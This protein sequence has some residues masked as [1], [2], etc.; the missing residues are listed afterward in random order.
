[1]CSPTKMPGTAVAMGLNSP[2]ISAGASGLGSQVSM[3]LTPPQQYST[4]HG[5]ARSRHVATRPRALAAVSPSARAEDLALVQPDRLEQALLGD[6]RL[7]PLEPAQPSAGH[8]GGDPV[9]AADSVGSGSRHPA[10][11][12][13]DC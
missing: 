1:M 6:A 9:P 10:R 2:R 5:F 11:L 4:M 3:W 7:Q 13:A 8:P 12:A